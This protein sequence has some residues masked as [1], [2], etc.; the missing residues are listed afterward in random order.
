M[1]EFQIGELREY[2]RRIEGQKTSLRE[3]RT[4]FGILP[5]SKSFDSI[6]KM[7]FSLVEERVLRPTGVRGEYKVIKKVNPISVYGRERRAPIDVIFPKD[8]DTGMEMSF[9]ED[10]VLREGD[11]ILLSGMSNFGKTTLCMNL[12][13]ENLD[14][15]PILM[16]N[17]Y[18]TMDNE[19]S[20][21]F[22]LRLD[23][24]DWFQWF[25]GDGTDRFT[26]LPVREDYPEHIVKDNLN[27]I[28]WI[29]LPG[30][31]YMISP[32][33]EGIK[34][35]IGKG[36]AVIAL[37]KNADKEYGR[38]GYLTKDFADCEL[39]LDKYGDTDEVLLTVG[40]VKEPKR[41][42]VGRTF[43]YGISKGVKIIN[44]REVIKCPDCY[45]K[46]WVKFGNSSKPCDRCFK[47][48]MI[49]RE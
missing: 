8:F 23:A 7:V 46:G 25:N 1:A 42:V 12:C 47:R 44:F 45:G 32:V 41:R 29:N 34:H 24:M 2:L 9:A 10:I 6:R 37:Q 19:P 28:D 18:T 4:E 36:I 20:Q 16:G 43:A 21:R 15:K 13:A 33:M 35:A 39:L 48:G 38:G 31:Y 14:K 40:K 3:L 30:E 49:D 27:I 26:L 17:E 5:G 11:M 22:L